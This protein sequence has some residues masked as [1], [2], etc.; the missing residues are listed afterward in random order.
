VIREL[1]HG[2]WCCE[3]PDGERI[4]R[5]VVCA[6]DDGVLVVD[7]GL[8]ADR[9]GDI[10][11]LLARLG[12]RALTVLITHPDSDHLGGTAELVASRP[13]ARVLAGAADIRH[14]GNPE[15]M[16]VERYARFSLED[17]VA[18]GEAEAARA[19]A[20]A[21]ARFDAGAAA[22]NAVIDLGGRTAELVPTPGH[23]PGH[24]AAWIPASGVLGAGDAVM[25]PGIPTVGGSILIPP[26]YEPPAAYLATISRVQALDAATLVTGHDPVRV[27]ED[28]ESFLISSRQ[29]S[30]R[31]ALLVAEAVDQTPRT[32]LEVCR[33]VHDAYG[34]LPDGRFADLAL[35]V[36]GH[37]ADL[38]EKSAVVCAGSRPRR[39]R[40]VA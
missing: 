13:D 36:Y 23:S 2:I 32:L 24:T 34:G 11:E 12:T 6:G 18:F 25:G 31:L 1:T 28:V 40:R 7:T 16:I 4:V 30:E 17:D 26:M 22:P 5:Q 37:L 21:G 8:A 14:V 29:A 19:R 10:R 27:G 39:F 20:R 15:R 33:R 3:Q 35:T 9:A 38:I